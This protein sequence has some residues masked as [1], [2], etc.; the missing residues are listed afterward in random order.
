MYQLFV[1][2]RTGGRLTTTNRRT[3]IYKESK[4]RTFIGWEV[5]D[6]RGQ[7]L[8][9]RV[10]SVIINKTRKYFFFKKEKKET[11]ITHKA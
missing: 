5:E 8:V 1:N 9:K 6:G 10:N 11:Y 3:D 7:E 2:Q 4:S